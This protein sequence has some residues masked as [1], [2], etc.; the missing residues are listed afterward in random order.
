MDPF[1]P[2]VP[3]R[4]DLPLTVV[5]LIVAVLALGLLFVWPPW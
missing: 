1:E 4:P 2:V 3:N 5:F